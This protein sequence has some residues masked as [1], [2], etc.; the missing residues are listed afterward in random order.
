MRKSL[1]APLWT[2]CVLFAVI[3]AGCGRDAAP[4]PVAAPP[5]ATRASSPSQEFELLQAGSE[6]YNGRPAL[7]LQFSQPLAAAQ[8]FDQLLAVTNAEGAPQTGSWVLMK[9]MSRYRV[10]AAGTIGRKWSQPTLRPS[11]S[12][13]TISK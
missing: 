11:M 9:L 4:P 3:L 2:A 1:A 13:C 12:G 10:V 5:A 8:T 6:T 7:K